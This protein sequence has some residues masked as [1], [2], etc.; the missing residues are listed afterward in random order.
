MLCSICPPSLLH[1][2]NLQIKMHSLRHQRP[3]PSI[4]EKQICVSWLRGVPLRPSSGLAAFIS[5]GFSFFLPFYFL[6]ITDV[7]TTIVQFSFFVNICYAANHKIKKEKPNLNIST[8]PLPSHPRGF[9]PIYTTS[10]CE[11]TVIYIICIILKLTLNVLGVSNK[12]CG[13]FFFSP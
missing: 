7:C 5:W 9:R 6:C 12:F 4:H 3:V 1:I 8:P 13:V 11:D 2:F 10:E